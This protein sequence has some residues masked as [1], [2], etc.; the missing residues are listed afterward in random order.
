MV[1][2]APT[3]MMPMTTAQPVVPIPGEL[4]LAAETVTAALRAVEL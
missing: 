4:V 3:T 1:T 2:M